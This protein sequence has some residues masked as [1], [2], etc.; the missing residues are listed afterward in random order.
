MAEKKDAVKP[1]GKKA[2]PPAPNKK[3]VLKTTDPAMAK[4]HALLVQNRD[5]MI[6]KKSL[7]ASLCFF[8]V[9]TFVVF[10][11]IGAKIIGA[12][13]KE[14]IIEVPKQTIVKQE[15]KQEQKQ[16]VERRDE[17]QK[18]DFASIPDISRPTGDDVIIEDIKIDRLE[19][20]TE[21]FDTGMFGDIPD[22]GPGPIEVAGDVIKPEV[23]FKGAQPFPQ[24][25]KILRRAGKVKV[26]LIIRKNGTYEVVRVMA[27][28]PPDFG[29]GEACLQYLKQSSW[30]P[31]IQNGRPIDVY[32]ELTIMFNLK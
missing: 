8:I 12:D 28:T 20:E 22:T 2:K 17:K 31:A 15:Q 16:Q 6:L 14:D 25:A 11:E 1:T 5:S 32:F 21:D 7:L 24:K 29:F 19:V 27:E 23:T 13:Q 26:R 9:L 4:Y 3:G 30:K 18:R 10:P